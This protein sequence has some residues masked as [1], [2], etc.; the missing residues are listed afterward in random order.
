MRKPGTANYSRRA[1]AVLSKVMLEY[2]IRAKRA[3]DDPTD[4]PWVRYDESLPVRMVVRPKPRWLPSGL[5]LRMLKWL[6]VE[7]P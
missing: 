6:K 5:W 1:W 3:L 2:E 4:V 7:K